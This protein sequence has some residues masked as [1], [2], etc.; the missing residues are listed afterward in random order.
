MVNKLEI[1]KD[2]LNNALKLISG[3]WKIKILEKLIN[4]PLRFGK[5]KKDLDTITSQMLSK[6]LKEMENDTLV[7]RKVVKSNPITVEYSL[8]Q[9]GNSSLPIIRS[10]V[11]W[12]SINKRK[13]SRVISA[14]STSSS[15]IF[16]N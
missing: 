7:K 8:T 9:F 12:G 5:L 14:S 4:K 10:L 3:K 15:N 13:M 1:N 6:Q 2:P 11:K 16:D